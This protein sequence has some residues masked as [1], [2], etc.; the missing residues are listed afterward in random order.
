MRCKMRCGMPELQL[1]APASPRIAVTRPNC[2]RIPI[3]RNNL[4]R[5]DRS[6]FSRPST[7]RSTKGRSTDRNLTCCIYKPGLKGCRSASL[8][9]VKLKLSLPHNN[10]VCTSPPCVY[11][12][13]LWNFPSVVIYVVYSVLLLHMYVP[14]V[15]MVCHMYLS[16]RATLFHVYLP[17]YVSPLYVY[18]FSVCNSLSCVTPFSV[19]LSLYVLPSV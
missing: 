12:S 14:S 2:K 18:I 4:L 9:P 1:S 15:Y 3:S 6:V 17:T 11:T 16:M 13:P 8:P 7:G 19:Y 5:L 10:Q